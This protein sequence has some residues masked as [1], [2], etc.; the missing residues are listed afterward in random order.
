MSFQDGWPAA[1]A[2]LEV[3][4]FFL[5]AAAFFSA[6]ALGL[7]VASVLDLGLAAAVRLEAGLA[8]ALDAGFFGEADLLFGLDSASGVGEVPRAAEIS[9]AG[10]DA[11]GSEAAMGVN[12]LGERAG[13]GVG[14][15]DERPG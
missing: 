3:D 15:S 5:G 11:E 6:A 7:A 1:G 10:E 13:L 14:L 12:R 2:A 4:A 9:G 8:A